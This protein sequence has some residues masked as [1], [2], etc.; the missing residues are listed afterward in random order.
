MYCWDVNRQAA[1]DT[2]QFTY[3]GY[4]FRPR[5]STDKYGRVYVNF[6]PA[7]SRDAMRDRKQTLR[8]WHIWLKNDKELVALSNMF[9][10][11]LRSWANC[12]GR[13]YPSVV[14]ALW[15]NVNDYLVRWMMQKYRRLT[16]HKTRAA[17]ALGK[18][19]NS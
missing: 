5:K 18:L 6:L 1:F 3:L 13:F 17:Q 16:G 2:I 14:K 9:N 15:R 11:V 10:P 7:A 19:A 8:G 12:Y 4:T